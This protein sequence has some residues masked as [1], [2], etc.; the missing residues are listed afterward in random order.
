MFSILQAVTAAFGDGSPTQLYHAYMA[1]VA[2]GTPPTDKANIAKLLAAALKNKDSSLADSGYAFNL[3]ATA[4]DGKDAKQIFDMIEDAV[5][6][7]DEVDG[8]M[9]QFEG[10]QFC[11]N[12]YVCMALNCI[13]NCAVTVMYFDRSAYFPIC[14]WP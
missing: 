1:Q 9:L 13:L 10:K 14:R 6:Q 2:L 3:A 8:K 4:L 12:K 5:V 11:R 7:A